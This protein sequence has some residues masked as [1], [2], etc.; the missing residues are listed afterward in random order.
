MIDTF[1]AE[2]AAGA[3]R[4][5]KHRK[6]DKVELKDIVFYLGQL[7]PPKGKRVADGKRLRGFGLVGRGRSWHVAATRAALA[8]RG[9][10]GGAGRNRSNLFGLISRSVSPLKQLSRYAVTYFDELSRS[11]RIMTSC[12]TIHTMLRCGPYANKKSH[13]RKTSGNGGVQAQSVKTEGKA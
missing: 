6:S 2:A 8:A 5:A 1:W 9:L 3:L 4:L 7:L 13:S 11:W 12:A 10:E